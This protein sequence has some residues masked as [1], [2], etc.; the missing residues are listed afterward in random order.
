M[1]AMHYRLQGSVPWMWI[2]GWKWFELVLKKLMARVLNHSTT[3]T[4]I[5][6]QTPVWHPPPSLTQ[7]TDRRQQHLVSFY[8]AHSDWNLD[9]NLKMI[10]ISSVIVLYLSI[11][12]IIKSFYQW[13]H[14]FPKSLPFSHKDFN[15]LIYTRF[16]QTGCGDRHSEKFLQMSDM[17]CFGVIMTCFYLLS[18]FICWLHPSDC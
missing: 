4:H 12:I 6:N 3:D 8:K 2:C 7:F 16:Y 1:T 10:N 15:N 14:V 11:R 9:W 17:P 5:T 18:N 13:Y